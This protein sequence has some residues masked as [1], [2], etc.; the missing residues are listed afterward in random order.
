MQ[1]STTYLSVLVK[2]CSESSHRKPGFQESAPRVEVPRDIATATLAAT[3]SRAPKMGSIGDFEGLGL[4]RR[5][6]KDVTK[7]A[8]LDDTDSGAAADETSLDATGSSTIPHFRRRLQIN[9]CPP[10]GLSC[11]GMR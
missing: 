7:V 4:L 6:A 3:A 8:D 5:S 11:F 10:E 1:K 9:I 2:I